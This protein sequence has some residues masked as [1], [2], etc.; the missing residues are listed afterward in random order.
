MITGIAQDAF[1]GNTDIKGVIFSELIT[2]IPDSAFEGCTALRDVYIPSLT[3]IG[4]RAFYG[5]T[6]LSALTI[7]ADVVSLGADAFYGVEE[8]RITAANKNV[9][10]AAI[11]SGVKSLVLNIASIEESMDN[12]EFVASSGMN[13]FELQGG[14]K[15]Y[16]NLRV[17]SF[18]GTTRINGVNFVDCLQVPLELHSS[19]VNLNQVTVSGSGYCMILANHNCELSLF[20][21]N[22]IISSGGNAIVCA[23]TSLSNSDSSVQALLEVSGNIYVWGSLENTDRYMS[24][25][26]GTI[27]TITQEEYEMYVSGVYQLI[28]NA[29]GGSV[30]EAERTAYSGAS[31]GEL[32]IPTRNGYTFVG[33]YTALSGGTQVTAQ[34]SFIS[35][36]S[37]TVYALWTANPCTVSYNGNGGTPGAASK[38]VYYESTYGSLATATRTGYTFA[39]WYTDASGGT[40]VESTTSVTTT[41]NH[42]LYAHWTANSYTVSFNGNGGTPGTA[43]KT[44]YYDGTYGSLATATRTGYTFAGWYTAA[45]GGTKV[46]ST[47]SV[48][49]ASDHTLYAHWTANWYTYSIVYKSS[50]GTDLGTS[51][52]TYQYGTT[53]TISPPEK[54]GY[55]TPSAQTV[56]WD[57]TS[58]KTI[59]FTYT[60]IEPATSQALV[61]GTWWQSSSSSSKIT[62][63]ATG[64]WRNRTAN[65]IEIRI[66][67]VQT[68]T[69]GY[70]GYTQKFSAQ[71]L[72]D[73]NNVANTGTVQIASS[74]TWPSSSSPNKGSKTVYSGWITVPITPTAT[75]V[76]VKCNYWDA[77]LDKTVSGSMTIPA[78]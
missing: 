10:L 21:I 77:N 53:N 70:Y 54:T 42:T 11:N 2:E 17:K 20:G 72:Y 64:E 28:F 61:N 24:Q 25:T 76:T 16:R 31:I 19:S 36:G 52:A 9:A 49:A 39:G 34:S 5:C 73:G 27:I 3:R 67:W 32:P 13:V 56:A 40:K 51:T 29:N 58:G 62:Y 41:S 46:E 60:R 45:S 71:F 15:E 26:N 8:I 65:S 74:T 14:R 50:N 55:V 18:S 44:V 57:S 6:S 43:S 12:T 63:A 23:N 22:R 30:T 75:S 35:S 68:I 78:Y 1:R 4:N 59:T 69:G 38:T 33:W 66:K 37:V 48:T 47:T 7:P